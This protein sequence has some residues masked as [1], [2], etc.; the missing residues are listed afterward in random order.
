[1]KTAT[2]STA[3]PLSVGTVSAPVLLEDLLLVAEL[4]N[5][6]AGES[7]QTYVSVAAWD[8]TGHLE[9]HR[10]RFLTTSGDTLR[11]SGMIYVD[12]DAQT[13]RVEATCTIPAAN[14]GEVVITIGGDSATLTF[15]AGAT[16]TDFE[17][18]DVANVGTGWQAWT[19][20]LDHTTGSSDQCDLDFW[21][22]MEQEIA[23]GDLPDP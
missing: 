15:G 23:A 2:S 16:S 21:L 13:I 5:Y 4:L 9:T 8:T 1:M 12:E 19:V 20:E 10:T 14:A 22:A 6:V 11:Y 17:A 7:P 18:L 3:P